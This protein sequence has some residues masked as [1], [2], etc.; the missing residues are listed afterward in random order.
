[1]LHLD[2][3]SPW[4]SK[5]PHSSNLNLVPT[6]A[7]CRLRC[8]SSLGTP[9]DIGNDLCKSMAIISTVSWQQYFAVSIISMMKVTQISW[10]LTSG[11]FVPKLQPSCTARGLKSSASGENKPRRLSTVCCQAA[12]ISWRK[13]S[14]RSGRAVRIHCQHSTAIVI[15][16][17]VNIS[18][19]E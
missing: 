17:F 15:D 10:G 7:T 12:N 13:R 5:S 4:R 1:M 9:T 14:L 2:K 16:S 18:V 6:A 11:E 3:M 19:C 8:G